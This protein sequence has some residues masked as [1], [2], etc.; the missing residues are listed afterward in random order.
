MKRPDTK[1]APMYIPNDSVLIFKISQHF[2]EVIKFYFETTLVM[3][4]KSES[5][6]VK[7]P[8]NYNPANILKEFEDVWIEESSRLSE[9]FGSLFMDVQSNSSSSVGICWKDMKENFCQRL[10]HSL[11]AFL[12]GSFL[13]EFKIIF[14]LDITKLVYND[15]VEKYLSKKTVERLDANP[16][17]RD[18]MYLVLLDVHYIGTQICKDVGISDQDEFLESMICSANILMNSLSK[19]SLS[20]GNDN[21]VVLH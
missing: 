16:L 3:K 1:P 7:N 9:S 20:Y 8:V 2:L 10:S 18:N 19:D 17:G 13:S 5:S 15:N 4:N 14:C 12:G 6:F 21:V 11:N